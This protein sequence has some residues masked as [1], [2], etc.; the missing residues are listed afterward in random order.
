MAHT[1][2]K[3]Y[4]ELPEDVLALVNEIKDAA[5]DI[6]RLVEKVERFTEDGSS[7]DTAWVLIG[8]E[9]LQTGFMQIIR[10]VTKPE[11]F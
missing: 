9:N 3:G 10:A 8:K 5:N 4:R 1:P 2:V 7:T 6:G 11:G